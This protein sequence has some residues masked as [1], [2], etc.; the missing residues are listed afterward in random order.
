MVRHK[1]PLRLSVS[2]R[3]CALGLLLH[4]AASAAESGHRGESDSLRR[5]ADRVFMR[6][7]R[8]AVVADGH[9]DVLGSALAGRDLTQRGRTGHSD[10]PRFIEG[11]LDVQVFSVWVTPARAQNNTAFPY[12]QRMIDSLRALARRSGGRFSITRSAAELR[13]ALARGNVAGIVGLEG[14]HAAAGSLQNVLRLYER[15]LRCFGLT[16]NNSNTWAA[17]AQDEA[18]GLRRGLTAEG[19]RLIRLLDSAGVLIDVSHAGP[20]TV[21]DVLAVTRNPIIASHSACAALRPHARNLTDEQIRAIAKAGGVVMI[22]FF[23]VFL[24]SGLPADV[25]RRCAS[26]EDRLRKLHTRARAGDMQSLARFDALLQEA[27]RDGLPTL[28][29]VA[30]HIDHAVSIA[31]AEHVGLG[32]DFDGIDYAP[33]GLCDVTSLPFLTRELLAR[34][35]SDRDIR[36][37]LGGNFVRVFSAVCK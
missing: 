7:H 21:R 30:D 28:L 3:V 37:I 11:G 36:N 19:R 12:A 22:N 31:G 16:W 9:N 6:L 10:L 33:V 8:E 32:S 14:G 13:E 27:R 29:D 34:G 1:I 26:M 23:P 15:G 20:A 18:K 24:R 35:Y 25:A 2:V 17:S 5:V 4:C